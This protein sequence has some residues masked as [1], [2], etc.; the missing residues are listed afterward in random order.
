[1]YNHD[2]RTEISAWSIL[3]NSPFKIYD[4]EDEAESF[5]DML[6]QTLAPYYKMQS[7]TTILIS[8]PIIIYIILVVRYPPFLIVPA[9]AS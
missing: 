4:R 3:I 9:F 6:K 2:D 5:F 7:L 8:L 1:M